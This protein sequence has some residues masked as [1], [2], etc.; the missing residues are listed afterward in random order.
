MVKKYIN[1][2]VGKDLSTPLHESK[3]KGDQQKQPY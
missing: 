2:Q 1:E 3:R